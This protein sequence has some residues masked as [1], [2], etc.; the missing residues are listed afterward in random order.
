MVKV[1]TWIIAHG[2]TWDIIQRIG[3][4]SLCHTIGALCVKRF[5]RVLT[6][7]FLIA[8]MTHVVYGK[9]SRCG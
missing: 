9:Q 7:F 8:P 6:I 4:N 3:P 2:R 5:P 1:C